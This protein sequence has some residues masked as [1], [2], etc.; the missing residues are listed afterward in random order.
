MIEGIIFDLDG[1][2]CSTDESHYLA[3][4]ALCD[5]K[6][7]FFDKNINDRLRGVGRLESLN[8][9]LM[10]NNIYLN[11]DGKRK[12]MDYKN[13]IYCE[14]LK[15]M[16]PKDVEPEVAQALRILKNKGYKLAIGSSSN[17]AKM[18]L[19]QIELIDYFDVIVDGTMITKGKPNPEVFLKA[20]SL[21]NIDPSC[22]YVVEDAVSGI[23]AAIKGNFIPVAYRTSDYRIDSNIWHINSFLEL[24]MVL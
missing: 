8:I 12:A 1:F 10:L 2:I 9:I 13:R 17:N 23:Q 11:E 6:S 4:K 5:Q 20:A 3:W 19:K 7:W 21:L 15:Q 18:I 22:L 14:S 24:V 16:T